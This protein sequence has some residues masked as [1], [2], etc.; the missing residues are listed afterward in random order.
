MGILVT[1]AREQQIGDICN[2]LCGLLLEGKSELR[3]I[4]SIGLKTLISDVPKKTGGHIASKLCNR[5]VRGIGQEKNVDIKLECLDILSDLLK[6]FGHDVESE[7]E[8][9]MHT[10]QHQLT[11]Q[12][13]VVRK[14]ATNC[15]GALGLVVSHTLLNRLISNLLT[16]IQDAIGN[17]GTL[18]QTIGTLSRVVGH[19]LGEHLD[20]IVPLFLKF[21]GDVEDESMHNE[22]SD[23]LRENCLQGFESFILRCPREISPHIK[24]I[25]NIVLQFIKY[26]PNYTY[27]DDSSD[28]MDMMNGDDDEFSDVDDFSDD[29]DTSW[30]VRRAALRVLEA[31]ITSR[32]EYLSDLYSDAS[33]QLIARFKER[34]ENVRIDILSCFSE[35]LQAT[36]VTTTSLEATV[37]LSRQ[38]SCISL[39]H[40]RIP[41]IVKASTKQLGPKC[42]LK[43]KCAVFSMLRGLAHVAPGG[44]SGQMELLIPCI[45]QAMEDRNSSL[46]L[47]TLTLLSQL[48]STHQASVFQ[49]YFSELIPLVLTCVKEDWYKI[50]AEALR[51]VGAIVQALRPIDAESGM[52]Q[53][54]DFS[55]EPFVGAIY[56]TVMMRLAAHDIDQEI[57][58]CAIEA[59]GLIVSTL[60]DCMGHK[61]PQVLPIL[62][63][64]LQN[65]ITRAATLKALGAIARSILQL[66]L[67]VILADAV[68]NLSHFLRQQSRSLKQMTLD[69]LNALVQSKGSSI[70]IDL[71]RLILEEASNLMVDSDL[72]LC[73]LTLR[74]VISILTCQP[75]AAGPKLVEMAITLA[76]SPVLQGPALVSLLEFFRTVVQLKDFEQYSILRS[77]ISIDPNALPKSAIQNLAKCIAVLCINTSR[78]ECEKVVSA[79][80][81]QIKSDASDPVKHVALLCLGE[82]GREMDLTYEPKVQQ[83]MLD[84]FES[85]GEETKSAAA[86]ALGYI[87]VGNMSSYLPVVISSL[88]KDQSTQYLLLSALKEVISC[89]SS[90]CGLDFQPY[91]KTVFPIL[92]QHCENKEEGVRNMVAE[93]LGKLALIDAETIIP[94]LITSCNPETTSLLTRWTAVTAFKFCLISCVVAQQMKSRMQAFLETLHDEDITVRR[95]SLLSLNSVAHHQPKLIQ[96]HFMS[97]IFPRLL[98]LM[99]LKLERVVDLGPFKHRVDDGLVLRK[100]AFSC[101]DTVLTTLPDKVDIPA[102]MPA[103]TNGLGDHDDVQMLCHQIVMKLCRINP[104]AVTNALEMVLKPLEQTVNRKVK[105]V[106]VATE[107]DRTNDLIRNALRAIDAISCVETV[108][109]NLRFLSFLETIQRKE[110]LNAMLSQITKER[111]LDN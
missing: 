34:E 87:C 104:T 100:A 41:A 8:H 81:N 67:S 80:V 61:L 59:M 22:T 60:G 44:L 47:E 18:I 83:V 39:L 74:L 48:M 105:D 90:T 14:R 97:L 69:T 15:L 86:H 46:K 108:K 88:A 37:P 45:K 55:F 42:S 7:H 1:K 63:E 91:V 11:H 10:V 43:S 62:M 94:W 64:R 77:V 51:V 71:F 76:Q 73:H 84:S 5:L 28:E 89:H 36:V 20:T 23:E 103:L 102:F 30:K 35:L 68:T 56:D 110:H 13:L 96:D 70:S 78:Q 9:I 65:E 21:C 75:S 79:F 38:R 33:E 92:Q 52:F 58:E 101:I 93:C 32:P 106:Q 53:K 57:K 4:Y 3:D 6:R 26:D 54:S 31:V 50:I 49:P 107:V 95:A 109:A 27:V 82:I 40:E 98:E 24:P 25:L 19:R 85:G 17:T 99:G 29:D 66:D 111:A 16:G 72:Q 12:R 2:K